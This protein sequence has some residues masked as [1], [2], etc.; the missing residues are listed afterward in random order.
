MHEYKLTR[1]NRKTLAIHIRN[2][3][4]EVKAPQKLAQAEIDK[5]VGSKADWIAKNLAVSAGKKEQRES[6]TLNY[7][8]CILYRG[9]KYPITARPSDRIGF[10]KAEEHFYVPSNLTSEEIKSACVQIYRM[11]AKNHITSRVL[12]FA[13]S[14]NVTPIAVKINSAKS[15]WGSCSGWK[16]LNF[17]WRLIMADD[18]IIDYVVVH[19]LAHLTEMNHS[20]RFWKIVEKVIPNYA[21]L[22]ERLRI[23]SEKLSVEDWDYNAE[24]DYLEQQEKESEGGVKYHYG[25]YKSILSAKNGM[26]LYRGCTHGCIYCDSR[27]ECYDMQH[28]FE[29]IEVKTNAVEILERQL[30]SRRAPCMI[31]TG[32]MCDPYIH[33]EESLQITRQC[34]QLIEKYGFGL[35]ILTKSSRILRDIELLKRINTKTKCVVQMTMTTFDEKLCKIIEPDVSTTAERF[36]VLQEMKQAEIPTV[37]WLSPILPFINDTE[38][39]LRGLLD[40]CVRA[41]VKGVIFFGAGVTMRAGNW[42][43]FADKLDVHFPGIKHKYIQAFGD[44]YICNSPNNSKLTALL[45]SE[46]KHHGIICNTD[47]VFRYMQEFNSR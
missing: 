38:E 17:S 28:D 2:G 26:N 14:M 7:G 41:G 47:E 40:Y 15:R 37:V 19:E 46:C 5:F 16:S 10:D 22:K 3:E 35:A 32:A 1:S 42:Q 31:A 21:E 44:G 30:I 13:K 36:A 34:L 18:D 45:K 4:V 39:N 29:D 23:I 43:Y 11:L 33:L 20:P 9:A 12:Y 6:F 25:S 27:S 24:K 8:D